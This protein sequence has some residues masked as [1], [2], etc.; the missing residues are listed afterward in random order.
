MVGHDC[1]SGKTSDKRPKIGQIWVAKSI[2]AAIMPIFSATPTVEDVTTAPIAAL[3]TSLPC[4]SSSDTE[5]AFVLPIVASSSMP[6]PNVSVS[7]SQLLRMDGRWLL[8][9]NLLLSVL[10]YPS[11]HPSSSSVI[12]PTINLVDRY[13]LPER[14]SSQ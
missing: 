6:V 12:V 11:L 5:V 7:L 8:R 1:S 10:L 3:A 9:R 14:P 13:D 4:G 2:K